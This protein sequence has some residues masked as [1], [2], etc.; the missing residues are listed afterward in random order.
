[1]LHGVGNSWKLIYCDQLNKHT[2]T[3]PSRT[4]IP[5]SQ[6]WKNRFKKKK[7]KKNYQTDLISLGLFH[8]RTDNP[9]SHLTKWLLLK[10]T[11]KHDDDEELLFR[12]SL[13]YR[14]KETDIAKAG[15]F[16]SKSQ[17]AVWSARTKTKT[18]TSQ[19]SDDIRAPTTPARIPGGSR[20]SR[21]LTP[22]TPLQTRGPSPRA[23]I[24]PSTSHFLFAGE[25]LRNP[26]EWV[27]T[28]SSNNSLAGRPN[29]PACEV[30]LGERCRVSEVSFPFPKPWNSWTPAAARGLPSR[31]T[32]PG[33]AP[34]F[35]FPQPVALDR[36]SSRRVPSPCP[37]GLQAA[38]LEAPPPS[39][40]SPGI[41]KG[42]CVTKACLPVLRRTCGAH[43]RLILLVT[44]RR[45]VSAPSSR[46]CGS[47]SPSSQLI[48]SPWFFAVFLDF[49]FP[50]SPWA[51]WQ[52][53][54]GH[55]REGRSSLTRDQGVASGERRGV[56]RNKRARKEIRVLKVRVCS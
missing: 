40:P 35:F 16:F 41:C 18:D 1:M 27:G 55:F 25:P 34:I 47:P 42:S 29:S 45:S 13:R 54:P 7:K 20:R 56:S 10:W 53:L 37:S 22:R 38:G 14:W 39:P 8:L 2:C 30:F 23:Y 49:S 15:S 52:R 19:F 50:K 24:S 46:L 5:G 44:Q 11:S 43:L 32:V 12:L 33:T 21:A 9:L 4:A 3:H 48:L 28:H 51:L 26:P 17:P 31:A 36:S 6:F